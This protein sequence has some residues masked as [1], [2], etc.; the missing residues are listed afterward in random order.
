MFDRGFGMHAKG[1]LAGLDS[2]KALAGLHSEKVLAELDLLPSALDSI[3]SRF[4]LLAE[5]AE[6]AAFSKNA[7]FSDSALAASALSSKDVDSRWLDQV[8]PAIHIPRVEKAYV[9]TPVIYDP[10]FEAMRQLVRYQNK[11]NARNEAFIEKV[12]ECVLSNCNGK[13]VLHAN[14]ELLA[15]GVNLTSIRCSRCGRTLAVPPIIDFKRAAD[16]YYKSARQMMGNKDRADADAVVFNAC[17]SVELYLKSLGVYVSWLDDDDETES[18]DGP[19]LK[20]RNHNLRELLNRASPYLIDRLKKA[21]VGEL[22]LVEAINRIPSQT[23]EFFRY[24]GFI[25]GNYPLCTIE[26]GHVLIDRREVRI[27]L[28]RLLLDLCETL[29]A[30]CAAERML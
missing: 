16:G 22:T 10:Q 19:A 13:L 29:K 3:G 23:T 11:R 6:P 12:S 18:I 25:R 15:K 7:L 27:N 28:T 20:H 1:F 14:Q 24:A 17:H 5:L 2:G 30:F 9:V 8:A 26:A 4:G 21:K